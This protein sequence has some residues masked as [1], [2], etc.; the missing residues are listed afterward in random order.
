MEGGCTC[1]A[2]RC[3]LT[4]TPLV[5]H[6]CHCTWCQGLS[7]SAFALNAWIEGDRVE[8]LA[9]MPEE[10]EV[11]TP[12]GGPFRLARCGDSGADLRGVCGAPGF[13]F[14][15]AGTPGAPAALPPDAH[16]Y[17]RS[18]LPWLDLG[19]RAPVFEEDYRRS[20]IWRPE[21]PERFRA[22]MEVAN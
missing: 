6:C 15:R 1:G 18:G 20:D 12:S 19:D 17:T 8:L 21:A 14:A 2:V 10:A 4:D 22:A 11:P 16:N 5:V 9:G 3:R 7:G 13:R